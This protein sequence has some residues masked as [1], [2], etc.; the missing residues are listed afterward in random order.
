MSRLHPYFLLATP[1]FNDLALRFARTTMALSY[2]RFFSTFA[3]KVALDPL[4]AKANSILHFDVHFSES[5]FVFANCTRLFTKQ[6]VNLSEFT[7]FCPVTLPRL[8]IRTAKLSLDHVMSLID[9]MSLGCVFSVLLR[10]TKFGPK[11][12]GVLR[13]FLDRQAIGSLRSL[14]VSSNGIGG[15]RHGA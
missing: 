7:S 8:E 14:Y 13:E 2:D 10:A 11:G 1:R 3:H 12:C 15:V 4:Q 9:F 5:A 6:F